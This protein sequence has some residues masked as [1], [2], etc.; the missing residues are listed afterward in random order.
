MTITAKLKMKDIS[1]TLEHLSG[2][3]DRSMRSSSLSSGAMGA[4]AAVLSERS[5]VRPVAASSALE[6]MGGKGGGAPT[7]GGG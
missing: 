2:K 4:L 1:S 6:E 3:C 7:E 5:T